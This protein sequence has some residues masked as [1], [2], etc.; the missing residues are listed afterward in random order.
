MEFEDR[1]AVVSGASQGIGRTVALH[2]ARQGAAVVLTARSGERLEEVHQEIAAAGGESMVVPCD[3]TDEDQ[4]ERLAST[5]LSAYGQFDVL[6]CSSGIAGPTGELWTLAVK[7]WDRTFAVNV[8]GVFLCCRALMPSMIEAGKGSVVVIGS[9]T[10]KRAQHGRTPYAASKA[11]LIGLVRSLALEAGPAGV[12]VNLISPGPVKGPRLDRVI[13]DMA[14]SHGMS[15]KEMA[16]ELASATFLG[17]VVASQE[18]ASAVSFLASDAAGSITG[19]D[20]NVSAGLVT[21]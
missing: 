10:G 8:G 17:R 3:L 12:R 2:F 14:D 20:L 16:D 19:E 5:A 18:V 15:E 21:Y 4:V 1:V 9:A 6:V 7:D 13:K 11:A